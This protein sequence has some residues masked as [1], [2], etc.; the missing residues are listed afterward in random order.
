MNYATFHAAGVK[1]MP[2]QAHAGM[3]FFFTTVSGPYWK[4]FVPVLLTLIAGKEF[5]D[6]GTGKQPYSWF[7]LGSWVV[8]AAL[9]IGWRMV[10]N[11]TSRDA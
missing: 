8:G 2:F 3:A 7:D 10:R 5:L 4:Y 9:A 6:A 1:L 11:K